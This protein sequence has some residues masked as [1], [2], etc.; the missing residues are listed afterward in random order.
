MHHMRRMRRMQ[1]TV[2]FTLGDIILSHI[3]EAAPSTM[4]GLA[5]LPGMSGTNV[6]QFGARL[7]AV[8]TNFINQQAKHLTFDRQASAWLGGGRGA[9]ASGSGA[10]GGDGTGTGPGSGSA[11]GSGVAVHVSE[12]L[13]SCAMSMMS[14]PKG[15]HEEA[16]A[17]WEASKQVAAVCNKREGKPIAVGTAVGYLADLLA[18][19][20][21]CLCVHV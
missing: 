14:E 9:G 17:V 6:A 2:I 4:E 3:A 18:A 13:A 20:T 15:S 21:P 1:D 7:L 5:A 12:L 19:G 16:L 11:H 8:V 10:A